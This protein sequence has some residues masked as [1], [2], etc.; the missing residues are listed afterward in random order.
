MKLR[1]LVIRVNLLTLL[2]S[3]K[4]FING[5]KPD[6]KA[7]HMAPKPVLATWPTQAINSQPLNP[8][9]WW[10][11]EVSVVPKVLPPMR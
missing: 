5:A 1:A 7:V 2:A 11:I 10:A 3:T 8:A 4:K 9:A 6:E